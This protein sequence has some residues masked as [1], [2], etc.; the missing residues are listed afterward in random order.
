MRDMSIHPD[1]KAREEMLRESQTKHRAPFPTWNGP[2]LN[3]KK[4][5]EDAII[6]TKANRS[7]AGYDFYASHG[8][9]LQKHAHKLIKTGI[10]MAIPEGYVG[11]I[12]PRSGMAY[13]HGID[14][15]AG[16]IDSSYRG[17]IGVVLYNS[18]YSN[19]SIEKGDRIAQILFQKIEDFDLHVVD[20]LDDSIRGT[21]GFG[22][23]GK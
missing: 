4:L 9:I 5:D 10:S 7:D 20:N 22:S 8:T 17:E 21:G 6:P 18:Q 11:L 3:V 14:V 15:F 1:E 12:W 13:K 23:S 16:V 2:V 19:Y